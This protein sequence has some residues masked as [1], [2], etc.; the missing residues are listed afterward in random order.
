M[1]GNDTP[2]ERVLWAIND[3]Q[4]KVD[5]L[6]YNEA[7]SL[8]IMIARAAVDVGLEHYEEHFG[9]SPVFRQASGKWEQR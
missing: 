2:Q 7:N 9:E 8:E 3:S 5:E 6:I 4:E 1:S